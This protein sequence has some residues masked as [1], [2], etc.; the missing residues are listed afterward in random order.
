MPIEI[1]KA[2]E[3]HDI[4]QHWA[5]AWVDQEL[6]RADANAPGPVFSIVIPPPNVTGSLH[7]GHMLEHT[8]IDTLTRWHRMRGDNTLYLPGTDHAAIPRSAWWC[9]GCTI[10]ESSTARWAARDSWKKR[11]AGRKKPA[12][13]SRGR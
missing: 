8:E 1:P 3:P 4:E 10:A 6:F 2:Y 7:I 13:R 9:A 5:R 12:A 11:G